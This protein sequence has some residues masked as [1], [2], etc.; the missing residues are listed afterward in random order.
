MALSLDDRRAN[1]FFLASVSEGT[2]FEG[3]AG[4]EERQTLEVSGRNGGQCF[5]NF[6]KQ[7]KSV[8]GGWVDWLSIYNP[9]KTKGE[10]TPFMGGG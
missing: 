1:G 2:L 8:S 10:A 7:V 6:C 9:I 4:A 3:G 5:L